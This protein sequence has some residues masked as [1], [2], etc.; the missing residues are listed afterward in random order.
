MKEIRNT[1]H[2][3]KNIKRAL[4]GIFAAALLAGCS[5]DP[6]I[7]GPDQ[8]LEGEGGDCFMSLDILM[9]NGAT[10]SR[11]ETTDDGGS[12]GG[13]E[14]GS[15]AENAVNSALIVLARKDDNDPTK[16]YGFIAAG[17]VASNRLTS[18]TT[19]TD[20]SYRALTRIYKTNLNNFYSEWT[21][22]N[23]PEVYVFVFCNPTKELSEM[24]R[25]ANTTYG[26]N[27]WVDKVCSVIQGSS[28]QPDVNTGIW[29]AGSFL[30]NNVSTTTRLLPANI[31]DWEE[32]D[33]ADKPFHLSANNKVDGSE[34]LYPDN[35]ASV[36]GRGA[37]RVERSVA[38]FDI[39]DGSPTKDRTYNVLFHAHDGVDQ[40]DEPL[41]AVEL[42]RIALVNMS[43][44]FYYLPRVSD[45]GQP[46]GAGFKICGTELPW[47]RD[48]TT[49]AY[50]QGNYVVGPYA[51]VFG[52]ADL[53]SGFSTYFNYPF[54]DDNG[55]FNNSTMAQEGRWNVYKFENVLNS[56]TTDNYQGRQ[57][58]KV[59]RY[60]T[61]NVIPDGPAKQQNGVS[62][63]IVFKAKMK[64]TTFAANGGV[65][66]TEDTWEKDI[67]KQIALCLNGFDFEIH[68]QHHDALKGN[69]KDDPILYYLD[70]H[71]YMTWQHIRQ[72]AIQASV[73]VTGQDAIEI[74]RSNSLYRAVFGEGPIPAG[75]VYINSDLS[76]RAINDPEWNTM[77]DA[78][79]TSADYAWTQWNNAGKPVTEV[80]GDVANSDPT[81]LA[82]REAITGAGITIYQSSIDSDYGPG[83]YCYYYYWNRHNDNN[84]NGVMGPMEFDVVRNNV[85]KL[86]V[87]KISRLGH[88]R[89]PGN[90]PETPKP[91]TPDESDDIYLDVT[92]Q[93][94]PWA[95]RIN[96]IEF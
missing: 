43:N 8:E 5:S 20:K 61:E 24:F 7:D 95:V 4:C 34:K 16:N 29:A 13:V 15:D 12:T 53:T 80:L 44:A 68:S 47:H 85:Y 94:T 70:G 78:W 72:A 75:Q 38:R 91:D 96:S 62:T 73:T 92:V 89:I 58:Y 2:Y 93:I 74:N 46:D 48:G 86:T 25:G 32:Y 51:S 19:A 41:V 56:T 39:R 22:T 63:G 6:M 17:E 77:Q 52:G 10:A 87:D 18:S 11:S 14:I 67:N 83:Y 66:N 60:V 88:P 90:Y 26:T 30:M 79:K 64:G 1:M 84:M 9:P 76:T 3:M 59:W 45:N 35:S 81:L 82:M 31:L 36:Q 33:T 65:V 50:S 28:S 54:F 40:P 55:E 27:A 69:S 49:G 42:Q 71:L 37:V 21:S 23:M 57:D